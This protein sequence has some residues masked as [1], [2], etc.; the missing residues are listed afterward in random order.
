MIVRPRTLLR[1]Y[2]PT[3]RPVEIDSHNIVSV[4][5]EI[6]KENRNKPKSWW[7]R[8]G[9]AARPDEFTADFGPVLTSVLVM[10]G[11]PISGPKLEA[12]WDLELAPIGE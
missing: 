11:V 9:R 8:F 1:E 7:E 5:Q 6:E 4:G 3:F 12:H 2:S 10:L